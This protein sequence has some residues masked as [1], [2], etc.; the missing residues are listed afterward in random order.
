MKTNRKW[1]DSIIPGF[2]QEAVILE[3]FQKRIFFIRIKH[4]LLKLQAH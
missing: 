4:I 1:L 2:Q 3:A